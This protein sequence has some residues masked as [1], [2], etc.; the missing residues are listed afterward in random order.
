[1][2]GNR[3]FSKQTASSISALWVQ[4]LAAAGA[5]PFL[6]R[7]LDSRNQEAGGDGGAARPPLQGPLGS[8]EILADVAS[9][10][11]ECDRITVGKSRFYRTHGAPRRSIYVCKYKDLVRPAVV[12]CTSSATGK[13]NGRLRHSA[14][15]RGARKPCDASIPFLLLAL[16]GTV[17]VF[18]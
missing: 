15:N 10:R 1:M 7:P 8:A 4:W 17:F 2:C 12:L 14:T 18:R 11:S 16:R 6:T 13:E 5:L 9:F 3:V